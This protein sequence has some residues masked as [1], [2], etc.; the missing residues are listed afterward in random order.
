MIKIYYAHYHKNIFS[1]FCT[2]LSPII[3]F[4]IRAP[5]YHMTDKPVNCF[6]CGGDGHFA[7]NCPQSTPFLSETKITLETLI[8]ASIAR[9]LGISLVSVLRE[10]RE[11]NTVEI[12]EKEVIGNA[13]TAGH[14]GIFLEI[15]KVQHEEV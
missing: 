1:L 14:L 4:I 12:E 13:I 15:A 6:K 11:K 3:Y 9:S 10:K 7:R 8:F 2:K 5:T